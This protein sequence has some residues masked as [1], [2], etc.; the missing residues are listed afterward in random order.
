MPKASN[1]LALARQWELL[2]LLPRRAPGITA[3][4]LASQL[5]GRGYEVTKRTIERDLTQLSTLFGIACNDR[6]IPY[7]WYWMPGESTD[8]LGVSITDAISL[9]LIEEFLRPLVPAAMLATLE[10]RFQQAQNKLEELSENNKAARWVHKVKYV[11][12][13]LSLVPPKIN[14][15]VLET[16]QEALLKEKQLRVCY[17][18]PVGSM[19][20][21]LLLH[22][23]GI[24][25]RG[26]ITYLAATAY[27]YT[28]ARLYAVHRIEQATLLE[29]DSNYPDDFSIASYIESGALHFGACREIQLKARISQRLA[30]ILT[31]TPLTD[32]QHIVS[33]DGGT[34]ILEATCIDTQ[35]LRWWILGQSDAIEIISPVELRQVICQAHA[36]A[37]AKYSSAERITAIPPVTL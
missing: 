21:D 3:A 23:L 7:G 31:E 17:R 2:R 37:L 16:V 25:Q 20:N 4:E 36:S 33:E 12:P 34:C 26:S 19:L 10:N 1:H 15:T 6:G 18:R 29:E 5:A 11:A 28:G 35:Q 24:A 32:N 8:L 30:T 9:N 27:D 22:P 13:T 14:E